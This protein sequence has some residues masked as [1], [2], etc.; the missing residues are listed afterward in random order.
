MNRMTIW[1]AA[2]GFATIAAIGC[3]PGKASS[4]TTGS[5]YVPKAGPALTSAML[6]P[7]TEADYFP[8]AKGNQ[9]TFESESSQMVNGSATRPVKQEITW[10]VTDVKATADGGKDATFD[11]I[12]NEK[13]ID[14]QIWHV[15]K[16]GISQIGLGLKLN[17]FSTPQVVLPFPVKEGATFKWNG[18]MKSDKGEVRNGTTD[19]LVVG[20]EPIDTLMGSF[21]ALAVESRGGMSGSG[22]TSKIASRVWLIPKVGIGRYRQE[23]VGEIAVKDPNAKGRKVPFVVVQFLKLKNYSLKK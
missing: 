11:M 17:R 22:S 21:N 9:W 7:G 2:L 13:V 10:R 18:T 15:G 1:S 12:A 5:G 8:L 23:M 3:G 19:G 14:K 20:P 4:G 16:T 6:P